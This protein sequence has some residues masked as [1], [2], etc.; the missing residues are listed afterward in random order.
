MSAFNFVP[1]SPKERKEKRNQKCFF[2]L[3]LFKC[4]YII[5]PDI[6]TLGMP[7]WKYET[8]KKEK[9]KKGE[10]IFIER[11]ENGLVLTT[12]W[13]NDN[14]REKRFWLVPDSFF[15]KRIPNLTTHPAHK[16]CV[17]WT[18]FCNPTRSFHT[19]THTHRRTRNVIE[20]RKKIWKP[21]GSFPPIVSP[22]PPSVYMMSYR[23]R[24]W[25]YVYFTLEPLA[26]SVD[27][28]RPVTIYACIRVPAPQS[29]PDQSF[30]V[31]S[32]HLP[33]L[34]SLSKLSS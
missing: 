8:L 5:T 27:V 15:M 2:F 29:C 26:A 7:T 9:K 20:G 34:L 23:R 13:F 6:I 18:I 19:R 4:Y 14:K 31:A 30:P 17:Y 33:L 10:R 24:W 21:F 11:V 25:V 3:L 1:K 16:Y 28:P 12:D 22:P 32:L